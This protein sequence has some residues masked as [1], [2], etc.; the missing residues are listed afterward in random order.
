M[1]GLDSA[2]FGAMPPRM[3][4]AARLG[5]LVQLDGS[6][7]DWLEGRGPQLTALGMQDDAESQRSRNHQA[8]SQDRSVL[9]PPG[10]AFRDGRFGTSRGVSPAIFF[11]ISTNGIGTQAS[12]FLLE[13][14]T[15]PPIAFL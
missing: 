11:C 15:L 8:T 10:P 4:A 7:H 12:V 2:L 5:E 14:V 3:T 1:Q 6:Q 9:P 13:G